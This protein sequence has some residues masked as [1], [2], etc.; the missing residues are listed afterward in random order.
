MKKK[1]WRGKEGFLIKLLGNKMLQ[2]GILSIGAKCIFFLVLKGL[3]EPW[4]NRTLGDAAF[5][6]YVVYYGYICIFSY[7]CGEALNHIRVLNQETDRERA[8]DYRRIIAA[9]A[10]VSALI[11][12]CFGM[13][14]EQM[15]VRESVL[16]GI[17]SVVLMVRLYSEC[18]FRIEINYKKILLSSVLMSFG[19]LAGYLVFRATGQW[20]IIFLIGETVAVIYAAVS[21]KLFWVDRKK[22]VSQYFLQTTKNAATLTGSYL[23]SY[24]LIYM[25]RFLVQFLL[26]SE[27]VSTYYIAT[28]YGKCV[29]LV[30][31]PITAVLL[32]NISKGTIPL[33]KKMV[34]K[35]VAGSL[36]A[37]LL[38]FLAGIPMSRIMIGILYP[39]AYKNCLAVM[40]MGNLAQIVY[41]S[42]SIV[43]M[44]AI[45]LCDMK[46][47]V[48]VETAYAILYIL[49]AVIGA[50]AGGLVGLAV[51]TLGANILRFILLT[52]PVYRKVR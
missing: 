28:T 51:G 3:I 37:V 40:D 20:Y 13:A 18:V 14:V 25:D 49:F 16:F 15:G 47:Q 21:G 52:V 41:Y 11:L 38:F 9:E 1:L 6:D 34:Y 22:G 48:F 50:A 5:G 29:A 24:A 35:V 23:I 46:L 30:I 43:N 31:P 19:Y 8:R 36:G 27:Q 7:S 2:D 44:M 17:T 10:L 42:C 39:G 45:R 26:G 12:F 32:S 33:D 4:M